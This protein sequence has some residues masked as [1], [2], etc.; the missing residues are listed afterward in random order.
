MKAW[1]FTTDDFTENFHSQE[2]ATTDSFLD[3]EIQLA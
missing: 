2:K 1:H 3:L